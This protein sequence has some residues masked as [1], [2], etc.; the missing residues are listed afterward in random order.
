MR[1]Q[2]FAATTATRTVPFPGYGDHPGFTLSNSDQ[3]LPRYP[4]AIA[5]KSGFTDAARHT[6]IAAAE[7]GGHRLVAVL[8]RGEQHPVPMWKQ[9]AALL[10]MGFALPAGTPPVG[11]LVDAPPPTAQPAT[12]EPTTSG[13]APAA[14]AGN[15][16]FPIVLGAAVAVGVGTIVVV[17][18]RRRRR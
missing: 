12:T 3:F 4:G 18:A 5:G 1:N 11:T 17:V 10:D 2:L 8:V 16:V 9:A 6:L 14:P 7:R 15:V 13:A